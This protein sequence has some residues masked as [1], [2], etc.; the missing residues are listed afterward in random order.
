MTRELTPEAEKAWDFAI[1]QTMKE[2]R[3]ANKNMYNAA[4]QAG[5]VLGSLDEHDKHC[6]WQ[7]CPVTECPICWP[8]RS[9]AIKDAMNTLKS[10]GVKL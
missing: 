9:R 8:K 3:K 6:K 7:F 1:E 2:N 5:E 10:V 4:K